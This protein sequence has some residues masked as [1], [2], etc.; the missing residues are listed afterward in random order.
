MIRTLAWKEYR[1][2]R[3]LWLGIALIAV[4][5]TFNMGLLA[6]GGLASHDAVTRMIMLGVLFNLI[7]AQGGMEFVTLIQHALK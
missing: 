2:Q 5:A 6:R 4:L 3:G 7:A 1:E